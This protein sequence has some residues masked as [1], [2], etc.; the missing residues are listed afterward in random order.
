MIA[1]VVALPIAWY[2][3]AAW[4]QD[5]AYRISVEWVLLIT[6]ALIVLVITMVTVTIQSI[7]AAIANPIKSLRTE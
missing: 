3:T 2:V 4:L 7:R 6:A 1:V 5:F